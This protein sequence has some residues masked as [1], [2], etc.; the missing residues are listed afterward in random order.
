M[1]RKLLKYEF[2]ALGKVLIPCNLA[3]LLVAFLNRML[4]FAE[5]KKTSYLFNS[6]F[7]ISV[8]ALVLAVAA[9]L[10]ITII[11]TVVRFYKHLFS[12]EGYLT[13]TLP[14]SV[15]QHLF[16]KLFTATVF[17][18]LSYLTIALSVMI[19]FSGDM[20]TEAFEALAYLY[21]CIRAIIPPV[22][23]GLWIAEIGLSL[24]ASAASGMLFYYLCLSI[25]QLAKKHRILLA[26]GVYIGSTSAFSF[27]Y[28]VITIITMMSEAEYGWILELEEKITADPVGYLHGIF[29]GALLLNLLF[30]ALCYFF[31]RLILKKKLNLE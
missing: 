11:Y 31:T 16:A 18:L 24:I 30:G 2:A 26:A 27:L 22:H 17:V 19:V 14:V 12:N 6:I 29:I 25:G 9:L 7:G 4:Q 20:L 13:F 23:V 8:A 28:T 10:V 3:V 21:E 15:D 1:V 5:P